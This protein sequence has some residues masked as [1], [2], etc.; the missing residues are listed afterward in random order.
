MKRYALIA[1]LLLA[2]CSNADNAGNA[3]SAQAQGPALPIPTFQMRAEL[4]DR[5]RLA[6]SGNGQDLFSNRCGACHLVGGMGTN[7]LIKQRI[8]IGEPPENGLL[9]NR[10]DLT[11]DYVIQVVRQGKMA[12]PRLSRAEVTDSELKAI[13]LYLDKEK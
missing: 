5:N 1:V 10:K 11:A 2:G 12:M 9:V 4:D 8:A 3:P 6:T 7:L 13:A